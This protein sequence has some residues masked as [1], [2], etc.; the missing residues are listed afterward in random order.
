[1]L[2]RPPD[3]PFW[4]TLFL[5]VYGATYEDVDEKVLRPL[6][7]GPLGCEDSPTYLAFG[8]DDRPGRLKISP[9]DF[10]RIGWL[11]LNEGN[12][13]GKQ[14][15]SV[16]HARQAVTSPLPLSVP[17]TRGREA[18]ML[19]GQRTHGS[20]IIPDDH[21]DHCGSYSYLW[22]IN[23]IGRDGRRYWPEAPADA[24]ACLGHQHG[25]RGMAVLPG[26]DMVVAWNDTVLGSMPSEPQPVGLLLEKF[27]QA[28]VSSPL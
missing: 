12:W 23:G 19:A 13:A 9:R 5:K 28:C 25:Q 21:N 24:Y 16:E 8:I 20:K 1:M 27:K 7:T 17:R 26:L 4:D 11:Y 22:W 18:P 14:L 10:A 15:L 2:Q 3:G 6:L